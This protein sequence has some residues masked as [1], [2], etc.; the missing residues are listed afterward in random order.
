[1]AL[2]ILLI[3]VAVLLTG[4]SIRSAISERGD[5]LMRTIGLLSGIATLLLIAAVFTQPSA[6]ESPPLTLVVGIGLLAAAAAL[7]VLHLLILLRR[8]RRS[9]SAA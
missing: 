6:A 9:D 5:L 4:A 2:R 3:T 8:G 7:S 1:M